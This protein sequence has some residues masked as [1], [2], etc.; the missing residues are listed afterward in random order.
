MFIVCKIKKRNLIL[1][2]AAAALLLLGLLLMIP[3]HNTK[4]ASA[5]A[6]GIS[7]CLD[8]L[9]EFGWEVD[10]TPLSN[11]T[12]RLADQL[13]EDYLA[14]QQEAGFDLSD[15]LGQTVRR[16]TFSVLNYPSG[17]ADVLADLLVRDARVVGGDIRSASLTGFI[18]SL[19][20]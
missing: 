7:L 13:S 11:E 6:D 9:S 20:R 16:Y 2:A 12:F 14:L 15:D 8:K 5:P 3:R 18:H 17:E 1:A 19:K 10:P 4:P